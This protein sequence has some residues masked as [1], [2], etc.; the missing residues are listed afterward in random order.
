MGHYHGRYGFETF[1]HAK[2]ILHRSLHLDV[3][4]RYPPYSDRQRRWVNR[5]M[6]FG[7]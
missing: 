4:L 1:T 7:G 3:S 5:L 2:G 6:R